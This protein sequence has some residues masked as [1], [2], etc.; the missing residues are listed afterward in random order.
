MSIFYKP[1]TII[2]LAALLLLA[3]CTQ[4]VP[5]T[6][7]LLLVDAAPATT[8]AANTVDPL[9]PTVDV[10]LHVRPGHPQANDN[11]P[12]TAAQPYQTIQAGINRAVQNKKGSVSTQVWIHPGT[13]RTEVRFDTYTNYP[14][15][16]PD[17]TTPI[18][19]TATVPGEVVISGSDVWTGW[20][21]DTTAG[22]F[23]HAWPHDWGLVE[24]PSRGVHEVAEIVRRREMVFVDGVLMRQVMDCAA[25]A[26]GQFCVDET[27]NA[28]RLY[29]PEGTNLD[30]ALVEVGMRE[31]L[32]HQAF[33]D[34]VTIQ[35]LVFRHA[36]TRWADAAAAV[37]LNACRNT[38]LLDSRIEWNNGTGLHLTNTEDFTV[39]RTTMNHNGGDGW[40]TWKIKTFTAED[41]ET[42]YN[43][44]RGHWG[45]YYV[46]SVGNKLLGAHG[47]TLRRH[48]AIGN[49]S[50]GLW[51]D[52]DNTDVL[53]D[54]VTVTHNLSDGIFIEA[55]Q[56]PITIQ[57]SRFSDNGGYGI[58]SANSEGV[59]LLKNTL[60]NN[61]LGGFELTGVG[62]GRAITDFET[63]ERL[64]LFLKDWTLQGN[65]ITGTGDAPLLTTTLGTAG[66]KTFA[67][68]LTSDENTWMHPDRETVFEA[69]NL[70]V[71]RLKI[72]SSLTLSEWQLRT[73][74]D[75]RSR[76]LTAQ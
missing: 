22:V 3:T 41:T 37:R 39:R 4:A 54:D 73:G 13:Y 71:W 43:N 56:G 21:P 7:Q 58:R 32:W 28:V 40:G 14:N 26:P 74:Q 6:E 46:W 11:G 49:L 75:T 17:N 66:W 16:D 72:N 42:S 18:F 27:I 2:N 63:G 33:E 25:L 76:F 35:G 53:L 47:L 68:S 1:V 9:R 10:E 19:V 70:Q 31:N 48:Q 5:T 38:L 36:P 50:R 65:I 45:E 24:D 20:R 23:V 52:Y 8:E 69:T 57:N 12:G 62:E 67:E 51:V 55:N 64:I 61:L 59:H 15:N 30:T 44:W 60:S 34:H 29:P